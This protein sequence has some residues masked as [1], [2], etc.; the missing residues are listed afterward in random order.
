VPPPKA[1]RTKWILA[2]A[3]LAAVALA[4][5]IGRLQGAL[6][7]SRTVEAHET[8]VKTVKAELARCETERDLLTAR[9]SLSLVALSLDRRNFGVAESHRRN[10]LQALA[11]PTLS[12]IAEVSTLTG[13]VRELRL[14]VDPDPGAKRNEVIAATET[15][16]RISAGQSKLAVPVAGAS[17]TP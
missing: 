17:G 10:A 2:G 4:Y 16:D 8:E 11:R 1:A 5:G 15:L 13:K 7:L 12:G 3:A 6:L 14:D 9:R